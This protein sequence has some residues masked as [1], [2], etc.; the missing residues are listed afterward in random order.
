MQEQTDHLAGRVVLITG[1]AQGM[2]AQHGRHMAARGATVVLADV[3]QELGRQ[4]SDD[5][6]STGG[7][8]SF[9]PLD[10]ASEADWE[11]AVAECLDTWGRLDA[12]VNNAGVASRGTIMET[13][14]EQ[15]DRTLAINL[16]GTWLGMRAAAPAMRRNGD[17]GG[18]IVNISSV[19]GLTAHVGAA[20]TATKWA[21]RG[22][23]K[24][25]ALEFGVHN[26]R[27]NS[28]HPGVIDTP[29]VEA[30][31]PAFI[32]GFRETTP[33]ARLGETD[34]VS[35]VVAFLCS[36]ASSYVSG[37]EIAVDGGWSAAGQMAGVLRLAHG[38]VG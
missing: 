8:S 33:L 3:N 32:A 12:L 31:S 9:V 14:V 13:P 5:L 36:A 29:L 38:D 4:M 1:A 24:T 10:V 25:A 20:Y 28:V 11:R 37:T 34:E 15:W 30:A 21:V 35:E 26:V 27:V 22:L 23:T 7:R 18:S 2:G 19:A 16:S 17:A 6:S